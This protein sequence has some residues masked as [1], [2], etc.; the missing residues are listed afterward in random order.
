MG[1]TE[2]AMG[3]PGWADDV[4]QALLELDV[5]QV[6]YVPDAGLVRLI[7]STYAERGFCGTCGS[8]VSM[9]EDVLADRVQIALGSLDEPGRE[10]PDDQVWTKSRIA[11]FEIDDDLPRFDE[12][13]SV[14]PSKSG[15]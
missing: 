12:S 10:T 6:A 5:R 14:V 2:T 1:T 13:S 7:E 3:G 15:D 4:F 9:H 8:T 11:W